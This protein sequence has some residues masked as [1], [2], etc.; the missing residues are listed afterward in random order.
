MYVTNEDIKTCVITNILEYLVY[1][2]IC[3]KNFFDFSKSLHKYL[4]KCQK[5]I[6]IEK[7]NQFRHQVNTGKPYLIDPKLC[8]I[9]FYT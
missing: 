7:R 1:F 9:Y 4:W 8:L 6:N 5:L 2:K 3:N